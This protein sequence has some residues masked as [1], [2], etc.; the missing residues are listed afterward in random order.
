MSQQNK[1]RASKTPYAITPRKVAFDLR[2]TPLHWIPGQP[3]ASHMWNAFHLMLP[4]GEFA[5][6]RVF[7]QALPY[8]TDE[9]LR[10]DVQAFIRQEAMHARA[11]NS[12]M[13]DYLNAH[14][15]ETQS[16][17][18]GIN[19]VI[20]QLGR[21][22]LFG[23]KLSPRLL[24]Q[25]II[26]QVGVVAAMEHFTCVIG[27]Y[28]L[29]NREWEKAGA[30]AVMTDLLH[31]HGAEE[32]EHRCVAFDLYTH[33]GGRYPERYYLMLLSTPLVL[34]LQAG[35]ATHIMKQDAALTAKRPSMRRPW[36]WLEWQRLAF[37]KHLPSL[38]WMLKEEMRYLLPWYHPVHEADTA[39]ALEYLRRSDGVRG[40]TSAEL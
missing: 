34:G 22:T 13:T 2:Q 5:F 18:E 6:C 35:A 25:W 9:K 29:E 4:S 39:P 3:F 38:P 19:R 10:A 23:R 31:W 30:D 12:A 36:F 8:I 1:N 11:H 26:F 14:G 33:L 15:I 28:M 20:D 27:K 7:N 40:A 21:E 17:V 24:K 16:Y 37:K 32:V